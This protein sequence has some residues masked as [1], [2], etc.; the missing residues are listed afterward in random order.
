[1]KKDLP[2]K[3]DIYLKYPYY[4][5]IRGLRCSNVFSGIS[6]AADFLLFA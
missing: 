1:M 4:T 2:P 3:L 5:V 6:G